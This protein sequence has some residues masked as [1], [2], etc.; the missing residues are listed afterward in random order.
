MLRIHGGE[1]AWIALEDKILVN[2]KLKKREY[3]H[4]ALHPYLSA[5]TDNNLQITIELSDKAVAISSAPTTADSSHTCIVDPTTGYPAHHNL[6]AAVVVA[7]DCMTANAYATAMMVRGLGYAQELL[8]KQPELTGFLIY[9]NA[10][11]E[12][13]FYASS[14][15]R[16]QQKAHDIILQLTQSS[17]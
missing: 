16:I 13:A 3:W 1:C 11:G 9:K 4:T 12:L 10:H 6:L 5:L 14:G 15:L 7:Q 2:G 17:A 8:E